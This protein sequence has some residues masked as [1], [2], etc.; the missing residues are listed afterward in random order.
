[1]HKQLKTH[2]TTNL[3]LLS[4]Q[5]KKPLSSEKQV[6]LNSEKSL[7]SSYYF[8]SRTSK[9]YY[10][11]KIVESAKQLKNTPIRVEILL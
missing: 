5:V 1:M 11:G 10:F 8:I 9:T 2:L 4:S 7:S 3:T 6:S